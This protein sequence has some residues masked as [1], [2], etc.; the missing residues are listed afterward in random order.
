MRTIVQTLQNLEGQYSDCKIESAEKFMQ[1]YGG[2][3]DGNIDINVALDEHN[4]EMDAEDNMNDE[5]DTDAQVEDGN[6]IDIEVPDVADNTD[7]ADDADDNSDEDSAVEPNDPTGDVHNAAQKAWMDAF[8]N[9]GTLKVELVPEFG[10]G[11]ISEGCPPDRDTFIK[12]R[13]IFCLMIGSFYV[14]S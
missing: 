8:T 5:V 3:I 7:V 2:L 9:E 6:D 10:E 13:T 11:Q 12:V 14:V 1:Q 4:A